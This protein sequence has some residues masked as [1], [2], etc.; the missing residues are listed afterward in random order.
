MDLTVQQI[1]GLRNTIGNTGKMGIRVKKVKCLGE[2]SQQISRAVSLIN[3]ITMQESVETV[4]GIDSFKIR[5]L[6]RGL[7]HCV[8][9]AIALLY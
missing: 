7:K 2:S 5:F 4:K 3:Q 8:L 9:V 6:G 1:L